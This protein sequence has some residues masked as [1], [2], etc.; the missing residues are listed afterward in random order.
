LDTTQSNDLHHG[1]AVLIV[2]D[3]E[4][5]RLG[6]KIALERE[7]YVVTMAPN[8][9]EALELLRRQPFDTVLSDIEMPHMTGLELLG[10]AKALAPE[11]PFVMITGR[12]NMNYTIEALRL[13]AVNFVRKPFS[14]NEIVQVVMK[15]VW[16]AVDESLRREIQGFLSES[17]TLAAPSRLRYVKGLVY[18]LAQ[19]LPPAVAHDPTE[20]HKIQLALDEAITNPGQLLAR[21]TEAPYRDRLVRVTSRIS[22][23]EVSYTVCDEGPGFDHGNLPDPTDAEGLFELHGR[24]ILLI[25]LSMDEVSFNEKGNEITMTKRS[26]AANGA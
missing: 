25:R 13:G 3:D 11:V 14:T 15:A 22:P 20:A 2:D 7:G 19:N 6:L 10:E 21:E 26:P 8:G 18:F 9:R 1:R 23:Q 5:V 24:G 12:A 17:K 16:L 4:V